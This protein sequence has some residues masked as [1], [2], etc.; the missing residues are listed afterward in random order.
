MNNNGINA[1][2]I[3]MNQFPNQINNY[4]M[5]NYMTKVNNMNNMYYNNNKK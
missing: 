3:G 5:P 4:N 2:N 1:N